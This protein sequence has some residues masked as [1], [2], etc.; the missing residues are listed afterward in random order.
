MVRPSILCPVDFSE[1]SRGALRFAAIIAEHFFAGLTVATVDDP[2]LTGAAGTVYGEGTYE[3][4]TEQELERFVKDTFKRHRPTFAELRL[5]VAT[6]KPASEIQRIAVDGR[7]DLIVMS[8]RGRTGMSKLFFGST[9]E[10]V[11]RETT[12]PVLVTPAGDPGPITLEDL[13][14]GFG[15]I[16]APVDRSPFSRHQVAI[17]AGLAAALAAPLT[18]LHVLE[19][20]F[21]LPGRETV[22]A[23]AEDDRRRAAAQDLRALADVVVGEV[24]PEIVLTAGEPA[25]EIA[26]QTTDRSVDAIVIGLHATSGLGPRMGSVTY[27]VLCQTR[28]LVLALP[29]TARAAATHSV[30]RALNRHSLPAV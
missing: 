24:K 10:R 23:R 7:A 9:T 4:Q 30:F 14:G 20:V 19:P 1:P 29:P 22:M 18:I 11:L 26:K 21:T 8:T 13:K 3:R 15:G 6:G 2:L 5:N 12:V 17:A 25:A 28:V 16:L 27:R